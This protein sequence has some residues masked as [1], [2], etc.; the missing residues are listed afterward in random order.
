MRDKK[1]CVGYVKVK[2]ENKVGAIHHHGTLF[3]SVLRG[4]YDGKF[5][6]A[7]LLKNKERHH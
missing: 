3:V 1:M 6:C 2:V 4:A 7:H 5:P